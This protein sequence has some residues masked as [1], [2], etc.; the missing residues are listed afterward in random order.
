MPR[1]IV[2]VIVLAII[3]SSCAPA[4]S[5]TPSPVLGRGTPEGQGEGIPAT[6][7]PEAT[8]TSAPSHTPGPT[9]TFTPT[10]ET[11][12]V[13]TSEM[14]NKVLDVSV[15]AKHDGKTYNLATEIEDMSYV[16]S[17]DEVSALPLGTPIVVFRSDGLIVCG[18]DPKVASDWGRE[19][20]IIRVDTT[21]KDLGRIP[22]NVCRVALYTAIE[23]YKTNGV[24]SIKVAFG[25]IDYN[26]SLSNPYG[27]TSDQMF[28][29]QD[30]SGKWFS[31]IIEMSNVRYVWLYKDGKHYLPES[32]DPNEWIGEMV[33]GGYDSIEFFITPPPMLVN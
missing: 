28:L 12:I 22:S 6:S 17:A 30:A 25:S 29:Q 26:V 5:I 19:G 15:V 18:V 24:G 3:L 21:V 8:A 20:G 31:P 16:V 7:T 14:W 33:S 23:N 13:M 11:G 1:K 4:Q 10:V 9:A 32:N 27:V 2:F